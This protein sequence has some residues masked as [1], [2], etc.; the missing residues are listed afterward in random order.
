MEL[1]QYIQILW[2]WLWLIITVAILSGFIT[3]ILS[4]RMPPT[5]EASTTL[6]VNQGR[7]T[8]DI[9]SLEALQ[10]RSQVTRTFIELLYQR[11][12][13][14]E[15]IA[16]LQLSLDAEAFI[17]KVQIGL[18]GKSDL[19]VL[20]VKDENPYMAANIANE[21]VRVFSE[22]E[23][24]LIANPYAFNQPSLHVVE[25]ALP[26]VKPEK[27][28]PLQYSL[29]ATFAG[30]ILAVFI[31]LVVEYFD[32]TIR[33]RADVTRLTALPILAEI[34]QISGT[35][36][37]RKLVT[38]Y[39]ANSVI[40][41]K[42]RMI[43]ARLEAVATSRPV[44][45]ILVTSSSPREG[46][47]TV[48]ANLAIALAQTGLRVVLVDADLRR[49]MQ[50]KLFGI[51][52]TRGLTTVLE[53][54]NEAMIESYLLPGD[55]DNVHVL[56][57][58][59]QIANPSWIFASQ[60][61][62]TLLAKLHA[63]ADVIVL[64]SPSLLSVTDTQLLLFMCDATVLVVEANKTL[65]DDV[66]KAHDYIT[67]SPAYPLGV[68]LNRV[69]SAQNDDYYCYTTHGWR[70]FLRGIKQWLSTLRKHPRTSIPDHAQIMRESREHSQQL[71]ELP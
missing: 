33:T 41:E 43:R 16:R 6:I 2:H 61:L 69:T 67:Q 25:A 15:T 40:A 39:D 64:D 58:G 50:H 30:G 46:K 66:Q 28:K 14:E 9:P 68:V 37:S 21:M 17:K 42:Y 54:Q 1:R 45:T 53:E 71:Q 8:R 7:P 10:V 38:H 36:P 13:V 48:A 26:P 57:S 34:T 27:P 70:G 62:T 52:N 47:S 60:R 35:Q 31:V 23:A 49:P 11:P 20:T 4:T 29:L 32:R 65:A 56:P 59:P 22:K 5:Y 55:I 19:I 12:I 44:R 24:S 3:L 51:P 63:V 18:L